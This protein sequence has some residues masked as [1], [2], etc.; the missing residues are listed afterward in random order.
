[1][2]RESARPL[3]WVCGVRRAWRHEQPIPYAIASISIP[4]ASSAG[5]VRSSSHSG[6]RIRTFSPRRVR[7]LRVSVAKRGIGEMTSS[8]TPSD[9]A[10]GPFGAYL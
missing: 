9:I 7:M 2:V 1:M 8:G 6:T 3:A 10:T 4:L 5:S